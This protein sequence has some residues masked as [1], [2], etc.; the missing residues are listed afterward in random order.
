M[1]SAPGHPTPC[2]FQIPALA[3]Y[4][5]AMGT[6]MIMKTN[7]CMKL[8]KK[9][10]LC[11]LVLSFPKGDVCPIHCPTWMPGKGRLGS[12]ARI[13]H[14]RDNNSSCGFHFVLS[15][16][17]KAW[18]GPLLLPEHPAALPA[19]FLLPM[20]SLLK[21]P[22]GIQEAG[23]ILSEACCGIILSEACWE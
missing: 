8:N 4:R 14:F 16:P 21:K 17:I 9:Y 22:R 7:Q 20:T 18:A 6:R 15:V 13:L 10:T 5:T 11:F 12:A 19:A 3:L 2:P 1:I 23:I